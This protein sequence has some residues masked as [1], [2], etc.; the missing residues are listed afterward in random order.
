[1]LAYALYNY[2]FYLF[3]AAFNQFFLFYVALF[4]LSIYALIFALKEIDAAQIK[5]QFRE[6]T[7]VKLIGGYLLLIAAGLSFLWISGALRFAATGEV[8]QDI[9]KTEHPTGIVY[10]LD[11]SLLIPAMALGG[12]W[13]W[14]REAWGYILAAMSLIK[15]ATYTLVLTVGSLSAMSTGT[16]EAS[17][18]LPIWLSLTFFSVVAI[19]FL[20]GNMKSVEE[21]ENL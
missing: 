17:Q 21:G 5:Q 12:F 1:M 2:A 8:P 19:G 16:P 20:L 11:L 18:E 10:A 14:R 4:T 7:P 15:G 9:L 6:R 13:L 3:A